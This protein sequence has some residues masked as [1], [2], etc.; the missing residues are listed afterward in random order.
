MAITDFLFH[1]G[2]RACPALH[3]SAIKISG[4]DPGLVNLRNYDFLNA[5]I[6]GP[7]DGAALRQM[8]DPLRK[9][10]AAIEVASDFIGIRRAQAKEYLRPAAEKRGPRSRCELF[11]ILI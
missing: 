8:L 1:F 2:S 11:E 10:L 5:L 3:T 9:V 4:V 6:A 7:D